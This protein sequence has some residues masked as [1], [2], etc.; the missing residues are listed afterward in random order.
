M[1][2]RRIVAANLISVRCKPALGDTSYPWNA[3]IESR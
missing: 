1:E 2:F 3:A